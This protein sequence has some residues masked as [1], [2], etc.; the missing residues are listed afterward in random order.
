[1]MLLII[2]ILGFMSYVAAQDEMETEVSVS[3]IT[4][5]T[6]KGHQKPRDDE[7]VGLVCHIFREAGIRMC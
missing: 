5:R 2:V 6:V 1:M 7:R 4:N 3:S